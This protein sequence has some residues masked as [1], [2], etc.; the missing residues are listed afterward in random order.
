MD[1]KTKDQ[2]KQILMNELGLTRESIRELVTELVNQTVEKHMRNLQENGALEKMFAD[3]IDLHYR[4]ANGR[5]DALHKLIQESA[6]IAASELV[7]KRVTI[8]IKEATDE[9]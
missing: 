4:K 9:Q 2:V 6:F 1:K 8:E 3:A 5:Y 7:A